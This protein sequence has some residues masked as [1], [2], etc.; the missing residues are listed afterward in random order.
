M[1]TWDERQKAF[2]ESKL[3]DVG[4]KLIWIKGGA[5]QG[6]G[7]NPLVTVWF[8]EA[9]KYSWQVI[10]KNAVIHSVLPTRLFTIWQF[11]QWVEEHRNEPVPAVAHI[12][13]HPSCPGELL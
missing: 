10:D 13:L 9:K 11:Q 8:V 7:E 1:K 3:V 6:H 5:A 12:H 2:Y 4:Q